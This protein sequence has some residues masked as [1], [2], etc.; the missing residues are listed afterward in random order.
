MVHGILTATT[1]SS[2]VLGGGL[3]TRLL[4]QKSTC[5]T[6]FLLSDSH[7]AQ[8][9]SGKY[10]AIVLAIHKESKHYYKENTMYFV[11]CRE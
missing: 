9:L 1:E 4:S 11:A 3:G 10:L 5:N 7:N 8:T 6:P 2:E